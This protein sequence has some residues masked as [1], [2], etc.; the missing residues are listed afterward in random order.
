VEK[1]GDTLFRSRANRSLNCEFNLYIV[2][3]FFYT[4][5]KSK[6]FK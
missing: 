2:N 4:I 5:I 3:E 6:P 1:Y